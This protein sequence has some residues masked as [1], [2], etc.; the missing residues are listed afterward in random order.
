MIEV[1]TGVRSAMPKEASIC[2]L[3]SI[4]RLNRRPTRRSR[5]QIRRGPE[6]SAAYLAWIRTLRC[7][8]CLKA[9][10]EYFRIQA[11][12]TSVLGPRGLGQRSSDFSAI[13]LC[14]WH[15]QGG[16][17]SYH[18]LGERLFALTHQICLQEL[19]LALNQLFWQLSGKARGE[20]SEQPRKSLGAD[21]GVIA[22]ETA[23]LVETA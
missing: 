22:D 1:E 9:P 23:R 12:H 13:P 7:A 14:H 3:V 19:V 16:R 8:V 21:P 20:R 10:S 5:S 15:H 4:G 11:A 2:G 17:D 6:R 18:R